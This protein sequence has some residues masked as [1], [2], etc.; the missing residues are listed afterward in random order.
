MMKDMD[1]WNQIFRIRFV[2]V[3]M[4]LSC[5][6][7]D[8]LAGEGN[9]FFFKWFLSIIGTWTHI[10]SLIVDNSKK[11]YFSFQI[12]A[13]QMTKARHPPSL[14][15]LVEQST[16]STIL[17][18]YLLVTSTSLIQKMNHNPSPIDMR[19]NFSRFQIFVK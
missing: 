17:V 16:F 19:S 14:R 11:Q 6:N 15:S 18:T 2:D 10:T 3:L 1:R 7:K 9:N 12:L 4:V 13:A 5:S 8:L